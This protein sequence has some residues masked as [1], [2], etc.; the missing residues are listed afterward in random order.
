MWS[1]SVAA[2][3]QLPQLEFDWACQARGA[4]IWPRNCYVS[5][6]DAEPAKWSAEEVVLYRL[7]EPEGLCREVRLTL[8]PVTGGLLPPSYQIARQAPPLPAEY[9]QAVNLPADRSVVVL[10]DC[11]VAV[12]GRTALRWQYQIRWHTL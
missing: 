1:L 3:G 9:Q 5:L 4:Q 8:V 6:S 10:E 2:D 7:T 12:T 11:D